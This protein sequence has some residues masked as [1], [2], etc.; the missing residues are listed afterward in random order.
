[1][2]SGGWVLA[3][4]LR[5]SVGVWKEKDSGYQLKQHDKTILATRGLEKA[6]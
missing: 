4:L 6:R 1:M 3:A 5:K 2:R